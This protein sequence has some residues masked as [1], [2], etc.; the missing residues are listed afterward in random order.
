LS[1][2]LTDVINELPIRLRA[3]LEAVVHARRA[4]ANPTYMDVA[5]DLRISLSTVQ[6]HCRILSIP[7]FREQSDGRPTS[8]PGPSL[9]AV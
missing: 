5:R 2:E 9:I 8:A 3:T 4:Y 7:P 6:R 1:D